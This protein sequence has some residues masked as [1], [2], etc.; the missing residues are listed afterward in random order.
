MFKIP[1]MFISTLLWLVEPVILF[2]SNKTEW[3][4][5]IRETPYHSSIGFTNNI[6]AIR[7]WV[8]L[9]NG[10]CE[11]T[12][13]H[14]VFDRRAAFL[15]WMSNPENATQRQQKLNDLREQLFNNKAVSDWIPGTEQQPGYPFALSCDQPDVNLDEAIQRLLSRNVWGTWDGLAAGDEDN[16]VSLIETAELVWNHRQLQLKEPLEAID[17]SLFLAQLLIESGAKKTAL[18]RVNAIGILQLR[19]GVLSDCNIPKKHWRHRMAQVDCAVRLYVLNRRNIEQ[20]FNQLFGDL[21]EQKRN[22]LFSILLMQTY[23]SGIGNMRNLLTD[24]V[25]GKA[26][27]YFAQ[28]HMKFSAEDIA[29]GMLY[30]NLGRQPWGWESL[31]YMID[32]EIAEQAL[33]QHISC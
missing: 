21:P 10:Y 29:T 23:H 18:S 31:Y 1:V 17:F 27:V 25:Q 22:R 9:S 3:Q 5:V 28:N 11:V 6:M 32:I 13:R 7:R 30:H 24:S 20:P 14:I 16:P 12:Q 26:A 2:A 4:E 15:G 19:E 8:L 33:C